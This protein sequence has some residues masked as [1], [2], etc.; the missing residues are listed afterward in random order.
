MYLD[1]SIGLQTFGVLHS[2]SETVGCSTKDGMVFECDGF[3]D[4]WQISSIV[5]AGY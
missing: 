4:V 3:Q 2:D 1:E 5:Q